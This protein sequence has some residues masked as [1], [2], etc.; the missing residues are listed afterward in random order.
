MKKPNYILL[1]EYSKA[2][3]VVDGELSD[4]TKKQ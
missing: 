4:Q 3:Y 1:D 2:Y